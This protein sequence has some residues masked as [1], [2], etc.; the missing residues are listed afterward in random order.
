VVQDSSF[1]DLL[2]Q[3]RHR[4]NDA[5]RRVFERFQRRLIGLARAK[6]DGRV[7]QKIEAEDVVQSVFGTVFRRL[8]EGQFRL[9]SWGSLWALLT[10]IT[11]RKCYAARRRVG[12]EVAAQTAQ[13]DSV[14]GWEFIDRE[15]TPVEAATLAEMVQDL[16]RG[17]NDAE[18][19]IAGMILR[20]ISPNDVSER[21]GCTQSKVYRVRK[22]L[23]NRLERECQQMDA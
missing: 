2:Q 6:L 15:P 3:L 23:R 8:A 17:L 7:R 20:G 5:A 18:K 9:E 12:R 14:S 22:L 1:D 11:V 10:C 16:L 21:L 4:D 19:D 13:G